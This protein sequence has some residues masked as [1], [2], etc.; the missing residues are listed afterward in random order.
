MNWNPI[1][2]GAAL[3]GVLG[4]GALGFTLLGEKVDEKANEAGEKAGE[5]FLSGIWKGL[6]E[7]VFKGEDEKGL[8]A[9]LSA[10]WKNLNPFK[11]N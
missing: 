10:W 6:N 7:A 1:A 11:K 8:S 9:N 3:L 2:I 5:G 4:L